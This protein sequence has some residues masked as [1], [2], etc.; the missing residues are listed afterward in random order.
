MINKN[1]TGSA[2]LLA[3]MEETNSREKDNYLNTSAVWPD[4]N[5][6]PK[7]DILWPVVTSHRTHVWSPEPVIMRVS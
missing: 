2:L 7:M 6:P 3:I 5:S 4:G 1:L